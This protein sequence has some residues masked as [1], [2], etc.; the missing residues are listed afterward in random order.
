M[1]PTG[2]APIPFDRYFLT[3]LRQRLHTEGIT[4]RELSHQS[5][6][7]QPQLSVYF[8]QVNTNLRLRTFERLWNAYVVLWKK[9][10]SLSRR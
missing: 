5:R 3:R 10:H 7:T 2:P 1:P 6:I 4:Q 8:T 9:H